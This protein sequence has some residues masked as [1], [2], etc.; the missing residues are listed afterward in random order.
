MSAAT[1]MDRDTNSANSRESVKLAAAPVPFSAL[2]VGEKFRFA[3]AGRWDPTYVKQSDTTY[4]TPWNEDVG[5]VMSDRSRLCVRKPDLA[6]NP[7]DII[8]AQELELELYRATNAKLVGWCW[9]L[10]IMS[11]FG[12]GF[13]LL[14]ASLR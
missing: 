13:A 6:M 12:W 4:V 5:F 11:T 3:S 7:H 1:E 8:R 10:A 2:I 9:V 14:F